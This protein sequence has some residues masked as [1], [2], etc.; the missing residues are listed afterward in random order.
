MS[1]AGQ[2]LRQGMTEAGRGFGQGLQKPARELRNAAYAC[3]FTLI[4]W[5]MLREALPLLL[6]A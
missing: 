4:I 2:G 6:G 3:C 1:E 5:A